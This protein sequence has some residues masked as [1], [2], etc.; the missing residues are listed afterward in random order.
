MITPFPDTLADARAYCFDLQLRLHDFRNE[1]RKD[2]GEDAR[3]ELTDMLLVVGDL[4]AS[5]DEIINQARALELRTLAHA[6]N[7]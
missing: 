7:P 2:M 4:R 1:H 3:D 5:L 6:P